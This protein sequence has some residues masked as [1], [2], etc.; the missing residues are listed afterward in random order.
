ALDR[1]LPTDLRLAGVE[2]G[3]WEPWDCNAVFL[4][5]HVVF[6]NWQKK[7]WRARVAWTLG[8]ETAAV[9][10]RDDRPVPVVV[11]PGAVASPYALDPADLEPVLEALNAVAS[12]DPGAF[13]GATPFGAAADEDGGS[14]AWAVD[15]TR[16][17]SGRPILAGDPHRAVECPGVYV[18]NHLACPEFD[19][20]GLAFAG[21]PGFPHFGHSAH[22]AWAVTNAYAD[23]QDLYVE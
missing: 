12:A 16:T 14:N 20:V 7:L 23:Y 9:L 17:A 11:P 4:V 21:V 18:Q 5:R 2:P 6:A 22:V 10:E 3:P 19:V 13:S 8:P 15:G 1:P